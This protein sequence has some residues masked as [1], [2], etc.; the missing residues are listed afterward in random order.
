M[1]CFD[2]ADSWKRTVLHHL[3]RD[4]WHAW[5]WCCHWSVLT[6]LLSTLITLSTLSLV[7]FYFWSAFVSVGGAQ[8]N[9]FIECKYSEY[10]KS[11]FLNCRRESVHPEFCGLHPASYPGRTNPSQTR[12]KKL[13]FLQIRISSQLL[14]STQCIS[15]FMGLDLPMGPWWILGDVFIGKVRQLDS[16]CWY[17]VMVSW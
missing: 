15:G 6:T 2:S 9:L 16:L 17:R 5:Y 12:D 7:S 4:S 14:L 3:L 1:K 11:V 13:S 8:R 10:F